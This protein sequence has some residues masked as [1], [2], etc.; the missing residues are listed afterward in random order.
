MVH[1]TDSLRYRLT[2]AIAIKDEDDLSCALADAPPD[3]AAAA[4]D[5]PNPG[6]TTDIEYLMW[7]ITPMSMAVGLGYVPMV[8]IMLPYRRREAATCAR[9]PQTKKH[10]ASW[11]VDTEV[12]IDI[13]YW[14]LPYRALL[15][16]SQDAGDAL[17][18][19]PDCDVSDLV[20]GPQQELGHKVWMWAA[21]EDC[22]RIIQAF[23]NANFPVDLALPS[24]MFNTGYP[25]HHSIPNLR[26]ALREATEHGAYKVVGLLLRE[27]AKVS[28]VMPDQGVSEIPR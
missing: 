9:W 13:D 20:T 28:S 12:H 19:H 8:D 22:H 3:M 5:S 26:P 7:P 17:V 21:R 27:G 23:V 4:I 24:H 16:S 14:W 15:K 18:G 10:V 2:R 6:E 25:S 1:T 11:E